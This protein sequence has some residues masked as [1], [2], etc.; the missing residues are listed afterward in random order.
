MTI[1]EFARTVIEDPSYRA[2]VLARAQA[3]TLPLEIEMLLLESFEL[4]DGQQSMAAGRAVPMTAQSPTLALI[5]P[6]AVSTEEA[7]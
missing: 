1:A 5:R 4:A 6:S 3:G 2:S 7:L